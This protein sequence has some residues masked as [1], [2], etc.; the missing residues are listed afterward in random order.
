MTM[1]LPDLKVIREDYCSQKVVDNALGFLEA[2]SPDLIQ[3]LMLEEHWRRQ[4]YS[5]AAWAVLEYLSEQHVEIPSTLLG[6]MDLIAELTRRGRSAEGLPEIEP[7]G[8]PL[9]AGPDQPLPPL[10]PLELSE[11]TKKSGH[12]SQ[13][14]VDRLL[15]AAYARRPDLWFAVAE[16]NR[17]EVHLDATDQ[18]RAV[19]RDIVNAEFTG[20][21]NMWVA[22][23]LY[24]EAVLR[25]YRMCGIED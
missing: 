10:V 1:S 14:A 20:E 8:R 23:D 18:F 3:K 17:Y 16:E 24:H 21:D 11:H 4:P 9:A 12:I 6:R 2:L 7:R 22:M 13:E 5:N 25:I 15:Q 19:L